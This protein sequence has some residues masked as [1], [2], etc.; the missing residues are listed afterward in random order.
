MH[1]RAGAHGPP[2]SGMVSHVKLTR[3]EVNLTRHW[4]VASGHY[5]YLSPQP[6]SLNWLCSTGQ[7]CARRQRGVR[8]RRGPPL[9]RGAGRRQI[10]EEGESARPQPQRA[11]VAPVRMARHVATDLIPGGPRILPAAGDVYR[12]RQLCPLS[13]RDVSGPA[14]HGCVRPPV[15]SSEFNA[16][17]VPAP[18]G[19]VPISRG[20]VARGA[21]HAART[22]CHA[23]TG[24]HA[25]VRSALGR[26]AT[27]SIPC[28]W[29]KN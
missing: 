16:P 2:G 11:P 5:H 21:T 7:H 22:A 20:I 3:F 14:E 24:C 1:E 4:A 12:Q 8:Q 27:C 18:I 13:K 9:P 28:R 15:A 19:S 23:G 17:I 6:D 25:F 26:A 29:R 10:A